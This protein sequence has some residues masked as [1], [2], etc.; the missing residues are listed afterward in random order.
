LL[1][2]SPILVAPTPPGNPNNDD[3]L[4]DEEEENEQEEHGE[5]AVIREPDEDE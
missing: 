5:P 2:G 1:L 4:D 3:D